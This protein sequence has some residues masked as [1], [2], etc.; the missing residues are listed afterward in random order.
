M[1]AIAMAMTVMLRSSRDEEYMP[2]LGCLGFW[3]FTELVSD[4]SMLLSAKCR[5]QA[6]DDDG[7]TVTAR[8]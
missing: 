3:L 6:P 1:L 5:G 2:S 8:G 7:V 4:M